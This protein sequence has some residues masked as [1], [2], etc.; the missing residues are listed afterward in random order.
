MRGHLLS[1]SSVD[2]T[3]S[4]DSV[5]SGREKLGNTRSVETSFCQT[6]SRTQTGTT[7]TNDDGIVLVVLHTVRT[8]ISPRKLTKSPVSAYNHGV[9][10]GD[11]S[12]GLLSAQ[13]VVGVAK[14]PGWWNSISS[15]GKA[16]IRCEAEC[17]YLRAGTR[18][19]DVSG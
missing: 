16:K 3:L 10:V 17:P 15:C 19:R 14:Y 2:T 5:T 11:V 18:K 6:E 7:G 12:I 4:S 8:L 1:K 9:F 13:R